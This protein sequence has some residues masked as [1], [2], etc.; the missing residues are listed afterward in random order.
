[1]SQI[2]LSFSLGQILTDSIDLNTMAMDSYWLNREQIWASHTMRDLLLFL[3][4]SKSSFWVWHGCQINYSK[5]KRRVFSTTIWTSYTLLSIFAIHR[6]YKEL[7]NYSILH[8]ETL[9]RHELG[10]LPQRLT[11]VCSYW[12]YPELRNLVSL[13]ELKSKAEYC[14]TNSHRRGS[15]ILGLVMLH[16]LLQNQ[17]FILMHHGKPNLI[18]L[19]LR[20]SLKSAFAFIPPGKNISS[21]LEQQIRISLAIDIFVIQV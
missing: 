10:K 17:R 19:V 11:T 3:C 9:H 14:P 21:L 18:H 2:L 4:S 7:W 1:M 6:L 8:S 15:S 12:Y 5:Q 13:S 20:L 16:H